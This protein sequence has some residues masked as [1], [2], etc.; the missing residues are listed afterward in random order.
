MR[1]QLL[2]GLFNAFSHTNFGRIDTTTR[3]G[4]SDVIR[5][6]LG[7]ITSTRPRP[8]VAALERILKGADPIE[9]CDRGT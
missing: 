7:R 3:G 9:L 8:S 5:G 2:V 4:G 6:G 1:V